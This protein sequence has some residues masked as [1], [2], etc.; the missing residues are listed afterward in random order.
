MSKKAL[1]L[2]T[3]LYKTHN[4]R[5]NDWA[6]ERGFTIE[7]PIFLGPQILWLQSGDVRT[8]HDRVSIMIFIPR[9]KAVEQ[10]EEIAVTDEGTIA[11]TISAVPQEPPFR[12]SIQSPVSE[13]VFA[14][15]LVECEVGD[16]VVLE[17]G[18]R[19]SVRGNERD[20][21]MPSDV[22]MLCALHRTN[23]VGAVKKD[24][25]QM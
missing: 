2:L 10:N 19:L 5:V 9:P 23:T 15:S 20:T 12:I 18:E 24:N 3:L 25:D 22:C 16:V 17:G 21:L 8:Q 4:E 7:K 11:K 14:A 1:N 13:P 6:G